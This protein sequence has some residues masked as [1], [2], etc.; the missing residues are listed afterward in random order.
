MNGFYEPLNLCCQNHKYL[1]KDVMKEDKCGPK[2]V[3]CFLRLHSFLAIWVTVL[4]GELYRTTLVSYPGQVCSVSVHI[5][6]LKLHYS[7]VT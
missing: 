3:V 7:S 4:S 1:L 5:C 6:L 2:N